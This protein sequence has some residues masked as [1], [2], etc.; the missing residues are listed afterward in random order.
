MELREC[1]ECGCTATQEWEGQELDDLF[2]SLNCPN[3][4]GEITEEGLLRKAI[5]DRDGST[6]HI[7]VGKESLVICRGESPSERITTLLQTILRMG[8]PERDDAGVVDFAQASAR[9]WNRKRAKRRFNRWLRDT[10]NDLP[11][12]KDPRLRDLAERLIRDARS[13]IDAATDWTMEDLHR[14]AGDGFLQELKYYET[15]RDGEP[16]LLVRGEIP[17]TITG[18]FEQARECYRWG[19]YAASFGLCRIVLDIVITLIDQQKR[20]ASWPLPVRDEFKPLLSCIPSDLL[21]DREKHWVS[22]FWTRSSSFLHGR[23]LLPGEDDA[24][25][26][27]QATATILNRLAGREAFSRN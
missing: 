8:T 19:Q 9:K 15:R 4:H 27:L 12:I 6:T 26:A 11:P 23:G 2:I 1:P 18:A 17:D 22:E 5:T 3:G 14:W 20:D 7:E 16:V 10:N 25:S 13:Q 24:W 21:S